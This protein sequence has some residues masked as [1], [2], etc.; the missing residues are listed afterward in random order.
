MA[1]GSDLED[2]VR[3]ALRER[4]REIDIGAFLNP[5]DRD[6]FAMAFNAVLAKARH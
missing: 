6:S 3:M 2:L 1:V 5:S 4:N